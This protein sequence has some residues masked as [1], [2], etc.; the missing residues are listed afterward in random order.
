MEQVQSVLYTRNLDTTLW[1][2]TAKTVIYLKYWSPTTGLYPRGKTPHEAWY[3][4]KPNL[5]H[6][7]IFGCTTYV[8]TPKEFQRKLDSLSKKCI[9]VGYSGSHIYRLWDLEKAVV[10]RGRDVIFDNGFHHTHP[11]INKQQERS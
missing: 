6:L 3:R 7:R 8:H 11:T 5:S 2:E 9:L 10:I 1:A 4:N